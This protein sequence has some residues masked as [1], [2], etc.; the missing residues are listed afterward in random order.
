[1]PSNNHKQA[2]QRLSKNDSVLSTIIKKNGIINLSQHK[3]YFNALL[4]AI[5][6]QQL[7]MY[8]ARTIN[9]RFLTYFKNRPE[10]ASI[11]E[12]DD[13]KLRSLGLSNAKV[14]YVKDLSQKILSKEIV[15]KKLSKKTDDE[16]I[17]E[18]TKVKG[19]GEWT[20]HMFLIFTLGRM[21]VLPY[22]DLGIRKA[23]MLNYHLKKM[24][25]E[26]KIKSIAEKNGWHPYCSIV[27]LYLWRSLDNN[28]NRRD[29]KRT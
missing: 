1:M 20:A 14:K 5:V 2:I 22:S 17:A 9:K 25:D 7:S 4:Q 18:L 27:S 13:L 19:I 10:P 15:L 12:T 23:V 11:L 24:P 21:N 8:A 16:I 3:N 26:K 29:V 6:G 28:I